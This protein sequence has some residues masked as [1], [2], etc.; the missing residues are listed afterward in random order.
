MTRQS[1]TLS[2]SHQVPD[3]EVP[4]IHTFINN[5]YQQILR[6][7]QWSFLKDRSILTTVAPY[8]TGTVA[9][10][11]GA[12]AVVGTGTTWTSAMAGRQLRVSTLSE[13]YEISSVT[14]ATN[15]TLRF[16]YGGST[17]TAATYSIFQHI[18]PL[19]ST[20][21]EIISMVY[22]WNLRPRTREQIDRWDAERRSTGTPQWWINLGK[23]SSGNQLVEIYPTP[24]AAYPLR[25]EFYKSVT[26]MTANTDR[27]L[28]RE[29][30]LEAA[31]LV[32]CYRYA[33][34]TN[35]DYLPLLG[36][37]RMEFQALLQE[38]IEEDTRIE[39]QSEGV[40]DA[41][42]PISYSDTF[43]ASHEPPI[44]F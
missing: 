32:D 2:V 6:R 33:A 20:A 36:D 23:D 12:T 17:V 37:A 34:R 39:S 35:R 10:T 19:T 42:E 30:V 8:D 29:D 41:Y 28:V 43:W 4:V 3:I 18:Y 25:Y 40:R 24:S 16:A 21:K 11:S 26:A 9:I 14:D 31:V 38:A 27:P 15:L 13:Y 1:I 44:Y 22:N 7:W 5:R